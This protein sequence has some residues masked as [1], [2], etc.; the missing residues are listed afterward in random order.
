[1][2]ITRFPSL[3]AT[4]FSGCVAAFVDS[5]SGELNAASTALRRLEGTSKGAAF[6]YEMALD[7]H[8]Y[9]ALIVLDRWSAVVEAFGPYVELPRHTGIVAHAASRVADAQ[10]ILTRANDLIDSAENYSHDIVE[11]YFMAWRSL[12]LTFEEERREADESS[13]LGPMLAEDYR[14]ARRILLEDLAAR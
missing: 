9:G 1:L 4:Q 10:Q 6:A 7:R 11:A 5:L 14:E 3:T 8:R 2:R 13:K 12:K